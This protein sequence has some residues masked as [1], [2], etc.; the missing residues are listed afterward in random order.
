MK[1]IA[2]KSAILIALLFLVAFIIALFTQ[3]SFQSL[4][5]YSSVILLGVWMLTL[6]LTTNLLRDDSNV[7]EGEKKPFSFS[8]S[9]LAYWSFL[10]I[11]SYIIIYIFNDIHNAD[12]KIEILNGTALILLGISGATTTAAS[13]I[14]SGDKGSSLTGGKRHQDTISEGFFS[15]ILSDKDGISIHRL[16]SFI[17][18]LVFGGILIYTVLTTDQ[19]PEFTNNEFLLLGLSSGTYTIIKVN[20]N[21]SSK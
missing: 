13:V 10:I 9:Q 20:E 19:L 21:K 7:T 1:P 11:G 16:Q 2:N 17:F 4:L 8:R 5:T 18:N 15:D 6:A 14:D 12:D 3:G